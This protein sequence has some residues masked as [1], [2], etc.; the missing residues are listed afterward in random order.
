MDAL[1]VLM[2]RRSVHAYTDAPVSDDQVLKILAAGMRLLPGKSED[3]VAQ[4]E[5]CVTQLNALPI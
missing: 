1:E 3:L 2:T 5:T 4:I